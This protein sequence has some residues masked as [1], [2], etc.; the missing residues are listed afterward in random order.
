[1]TAA[2]LIARG[3]DQDLVAQLINSVVAAL[4][5]LVDLFVTKAHRQEVD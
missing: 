1:M 5:V 2:Y 3:L 4:L